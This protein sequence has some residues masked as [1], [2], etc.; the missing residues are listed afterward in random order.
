VEVNSSKSIRQMIVACAEWV[1]NLPVVPLAYAAEDQQP[2]R[3]AKQPYLEFGFHSPGS[4]AVITVREKTAIS[5][6]GSLS[7]L[8]A[9]FGN[10]GDPEKSWCFWCVSLNVTHAPEMLRY[11]LQEAI[12]WNAPLSDP[13]RVADAFQR[14][15][16]QFHLQT[17]LHE[18][19]LK[20]EFLGFLAELHEN[21]TAAGVGDNRAWQRA[22]EYIYR[23]YAEHDLCLENIARAAALS[24][25]QLC[26][27]FRAEK[28]TTPMKYVTD[29]R[30]E[31][32]ADLLRKT[33]KSVKEVAA[34]VG[35]ADPLHFS[36]VFRRRHGRPPV[37]FKQ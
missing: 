35:F 18:I 3:T 6:P 11:C 30:L 28:G 16:K 31:R 33:S 2:V 5:R 32:A 34:A 17:G 19:R 22:M 27:V 37:T 24:V 29:M 13:P 15:A 7:V 20:S 14:L 21:V 23:H 4:P 10:Q 1:S 8:N 9:I 25:S 36:R 12:L 26:R